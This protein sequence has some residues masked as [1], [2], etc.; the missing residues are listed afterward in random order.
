MRRVAETVGFVHDLIA[1]GGAFALRPVGTDCILQDRTCTVA[2]RS[3]RC[4]L[5]PSRF[6]RFGGRDARRL[7]SFLV[8]LG[9]FDC[10]GGQTF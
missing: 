3:H 1:A 2:L 8:L 10:A 5:G 9:R 6:H 7:Q 4:C